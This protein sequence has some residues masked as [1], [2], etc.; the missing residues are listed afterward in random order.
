MITQVN[1]SAKIINASGEADTSERMLN[2]EYYDSI[3][4]QW[5]NLFGP[6]GY[7]S[8]EYFAS[9]D[10]NTSVDDWTR[11][12]KIIDAGFFPAIRLVDA[13]SIKQTVTKVLA[14]GGNIDLRSGTVFSKGAFLEAASK[15]TKAAKS[16]KT[17]KATRTTKAKTL[18]SKNVSAAKETESNLYSKMDAYIVDFGNVWLVTP[19]Q[20]F[21]LVNQA[22]AAGK[23]FAL[24]AGTKEPGEGGN[25][26]AL[27]QQIQNQNAQIASL[28]T[29]NQSLMTQVVTLQN[30]VQLQTG[31]IATLNATVQTRTAQVTTLT[32]QV[33]THLATIQTLQARI[34]SLE[35]T[36]SGQRTQEANKVYSNVVSEITKA[37]DSLSNSNYKLSN[38]ALDLK[39]LVKN[40]ENGLKLQ[41]VDDTLAETIDGSSLS[42][43]RIEVKA[44]EIGNVNTVVNPLPSI[45]GLTESEARKKLMNYGL[46]LNPI[47]QF[48]DKYTLG[49]AFKQYPEANTE[50]MEGSVITVIFAKDKN[51]Y[52]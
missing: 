32:N 14:F 35:N 18:A 47:Y 13:D 24:I 40:D 4:F 36:Q 48:S 19:D 28:Q 27:M 52:N 3:N 46:K 25:V 6:V 51:K 22:Q 30:T 41:L 21:Q 31:Q 15:T 50:L 49:Q 37:A 12:G 9:L 8:G 5:T 1:F 44:N 2:L 33:Q 39:V 20:E 17:T 45:L 29:S 34:A 38:L 16:T 7:N 43:I 10:L 11:F 42:N 23:N 26:D